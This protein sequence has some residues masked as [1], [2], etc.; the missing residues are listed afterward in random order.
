MAKTQKSVLVLA[1][2]EPTKA[3]P[4]SQSRGYPG[5]GFFR[6]TKMSQWK[7]VGRFECWQGAC[8]HGAGCDH[9][10]VIEKC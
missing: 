5:L 1:W 6:L 10:F 9:I 8:R 7:V 2:G 3:A 4:I